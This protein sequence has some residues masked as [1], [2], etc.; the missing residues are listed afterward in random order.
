[1]KVSIIT[2]TFNSEPYIAKTI[3]SVLAQS[4]QNWE[5]IIIDD[6]SYDKSREIISSYCKQDRRIKL[7][8]MPF[9]SGTAKA[10]NLAIQKAQGEY[11]AFLDSDDLWLPEKLEKQILCMQEHNISLCYTSYKVIDEYDKIIG[12][13]NATDTVTY[14]EMLKTSIIGTS[15]MIYNCRILGKRYFNTHGHEDYTFKLHILKDIPYAKNIDEYLTQYRISS[16]SLSANKLKAAS[17]QWHI[18]RKIECLP[19]YKSIYFFLHYI[20]HGLTKYK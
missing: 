16:T 18:Y 6:C 17:W 9:N 12:Y 8:Q 3:E 7:F 10:R 2:P 19:L 20:Y 15:T 4:Y 1:M 11:I 13:F 14:K 5:M